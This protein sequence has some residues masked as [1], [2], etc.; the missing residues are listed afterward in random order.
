MRIR[1]IQST[2]KIKEIIESYLYRGRYPSFQTITQQFGK[3]LQDHNLGVPLFQP[4][5]VMRKEKSSYEKYNHHIEQIDVDI[6]DAYQATIEQ[7]TQV[8]SDFNFIEV[9]RKKINH[10][11]T[12]LSKQIDELLLT[13]RNADFQYFDGYTISFEDLNDV[14]SKNSSIFVD[15]TSKELTLKEN[16]QQNN[17][18]IINPSLSS[19][20]T[21]LPATKHEALESVKHAFDDNINTAW[22]HVVKTKELS[23][24]H[25]MRAE[26]KIM[27]TQE[28]TINH[29]EYIPH[30]AKPVNIRLEYTTDG[31]SFTSIQRNAESDKVTGTKIWD[32]ETISCTGIK[33][34]FDKSDYDERSND[35]YNYYFGAKNI[36][37]HKK[38][39]VSEG[40]YY[41]NPI[42]FDKNI[43]QVSI[44]TQDKI[45]TNTDLRYEIALQEDGKDLDQLTWYPISSNDVSN[46]K[47]AKVVHLR[48]KENKK[49]ETSKAESTGEIING[50]KVFR[51]IRDNNSA[52]MSEEFENDNLARRKE[53]FDTFHN[54]KLFRGINQW[55]RERTY[56][57]FLGKTPLNSHW[58]ERY[59]NHPELIRTDYLMKG[60]RLDLTRYDGGF[61]DNFYRFNISIFS[62]VPRN[63]PLSLTI[64][65][66]LNTYKR[67]RLGTYSVYVNG[68][69]L[70]PSNDEVTMPFVKGW[71]EIQILYHWGNVQERKDSSRENLPENTILGKFN[72]QLEET[73]RGDYE[74]MQYVDAHSLYHN[75]S[76]NNRNYFSIYK[77]Q[78]VLNYL[79]KSCIFQ[80]FYKSDGQENEHNQV[81]IRSHLNRDINSPNVSPK[82]HRIQLRAK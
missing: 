33:F 78:V 21:L 30:H 61:D 7:T 19:F 70:A 80:F 75:I 55:K 47:Y 26:F 56:I 36:S 41:S 42:V 68:E 54:A 79:P 64:L 69:R 49:V 11:L 8:M 29:I 32:F 24:D 18:I 51:L 43:E 4:L 50:M 58:E 39:Y 37:I 1:N 46:P 2:R 62:D 72:F 20:Q 31:S 13:S 45:P 10:E 77:Q 76:P 81:L 59:S 38:N 15:V 23:N 22:W 34:V 28:E 52:I 67:K 25:H 17:R 57:P 53:T 74:P 12:L 35:Y 6:K 82:I 71:N 66:S 73:V 3:W 27:F 63:E 9:N 44:F 60:N 5:K 16:V 40:V 65:T 48:T 14:D